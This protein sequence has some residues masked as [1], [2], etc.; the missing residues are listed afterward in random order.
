MILPV[1]PGGK[2]ETIKGRRGDPSAFVVTVQSGIPLAGALRTGP[3]RNGPAQPWRALKR[4][5]ALLIT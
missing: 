1:R 2:A 5:L 3:E 4:G